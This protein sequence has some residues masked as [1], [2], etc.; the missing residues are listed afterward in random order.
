MRKSYF[1]FFSI[2]LILTTVSTFYLQQQ[3]NINIKDAGLINLAGKQRMLSQR[4]A[5]SI[6]S[7]F[8]A[9]NLNEH[10]RYL[11]M[12]GNSLDEF[13]L[14]HLKLTHTD[15]NSSIELPLSKATK[16]LYY[17]N[18]TGLD[19]LMH[20]Y[21]VKAKYYLDVK[22]ASN[23]KMQPFPSE[24]SSALL[25]KLNSSV[26]LFEQE[27][28]EHGEY[29]SLTINMVWLAVLVTLLGSTVFIYLPTE[30][31]VLK[32]IA[33]LRKSMRYAVRSRKEARQANNSKSQILTDIERELRTPVINVFGLLDLAIFEK[34]EKVK[35]KLL[36][37]VKDAGYSLVKLLNNLLDSAKIETKSLSLSVCETNLFKLLDEC[38]APIA[39]DCSRK[40]ITFVFTSHSAIPE[41]I[42]CDP[43]RLSQVINNLLSNAVKF[44]EIGGVKVDLHVQ[45]NGSVFNFD[46]SVRDT[47][48]GISP[49]NLEHIF[50]KFSKIEHDESRHYKGMGLGLNITQKI[51]EEMK[52]SIEVNSSEGKGSD[53]SVQLK[54][55]RSSETNVNSTVIESMQNRNFAIVDELETSGLYVASLLRNEGFDVDIFASGAELLKQKE[56]LIEYAAV[57]IDLHVQDIKAFEIT[58]TIRAIHADKAPEF[59]FISASSEAIDTIKNIFKGSHYI[60]AKPIDPTHFLDTIRLITKPV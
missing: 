10:T 14:N 18:E 41:Y 43:V 31:V 51:I 46:L 6:Q 48:I 55:Q 22:F 25:V 49:N 34:E 57:I 4:I 56:M 52:G 5:F 15:P 8:L 50:D 40:E 45:E 39:I 9:T 47:G 21:V 38:M 11:S 54:L 23:I 12:L 60:F 1:S 26:T 20:E 58:E 2:I 24:L 16:L 13:E 42:R 29:L 27:A 3:I 30:K 17:N 33:R 36:N 32:S 44:T 28:N 59:I 53:F 37:K 35:D 19:A 7:M